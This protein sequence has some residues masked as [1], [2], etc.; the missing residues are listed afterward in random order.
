MAHGPDSLAAARS[1][2]VVEY[3]TV[4]SEDGTERAVGTI[5]KIGSALIRWGGDGIPN[6]TSSRTANVLDDKEEDGIPMAAP[7]ALQDKRSIWV[8]RYVYIASMIQNL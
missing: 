7:E 8:D 2:E 5:P 1:L 6:P 3:K 4:V